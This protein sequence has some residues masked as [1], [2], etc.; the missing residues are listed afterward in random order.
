MKPFLRGLL[1]SDGSRFANRVRVDGRLYSYP[2][3]TFTNASSDIR[4]LFCDA[5]ELLDIEWRVMNAR[6]ISVAKRASVA[7]LDEFVGPE[8]VGRGVQRV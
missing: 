6:N 8:A 7:C 4:R 5:C 1:H 2:R 3:C